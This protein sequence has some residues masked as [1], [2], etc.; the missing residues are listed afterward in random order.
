MRSPTPVIAIQQQLH[1]PLMKD[2][3]VLLFPTMA[4]ANRYLRR[5]PEGN[6]VPVKCEVTKV[7]KHDAEEQAVVGEVVVP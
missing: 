3:K 4:Q 2:G 1:V 7:P 6:F 5:H